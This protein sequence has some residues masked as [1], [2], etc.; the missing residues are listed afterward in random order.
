MDVEQSAARMEA[1]M[2]VQWIHYS[3]EVL[4]GYMRASCTQ[5]SRCRRPRLARRSWARR[6]P[7]V[8]SPR[9]HVQLQRFPILPEQ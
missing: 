3:D 6:V 1:E 9:L 7:N 5:E 8:R 4:V 2:Q